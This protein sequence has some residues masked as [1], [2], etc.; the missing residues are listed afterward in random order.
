M[1]INFCEVQLHKMNFWHFC[2]E[3]ANFKSCTYFSTKA[4]MYEKWDI[5]FLHEGNWREGKDSLILFLLACLWKD[6]EM[7]RTSPS[8][9]T[10]CLCSGGCWMPHVFFIQL[11]QAG[12]CGVV[13]GLVFLIAH[14]WTPGPLATL[15][16]HTIPTWRHT[17]RFRDNTA[18]F[19]VLPAVCMRQY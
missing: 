17:S 9:G 3:C 11:I 2:V 8:P 10:V 1:V 4:R 6:N 16:P 18:V 14:L 5:V 15:T 12:S 19:V 13:L 7:N